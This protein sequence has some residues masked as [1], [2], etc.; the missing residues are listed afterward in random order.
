MAIWNLSKLFLLCVVL[1]LSG[2][3]SGAKDM[4]WETSTQPVYQAGPGTAV[5]GKRWSMGARS[6]DVNFYIHLDAQTNMQRG[7]WYGEIRSYE[8]FYIKAYLVTQDGQ[9]LFLKLKDVKARGPDSAY[10]SWKDGPVTTRYQS[11]TFDFK[12]KELKT[13]STYSA[14]VIGYS[15]YKNSKKVKNISFPLKTFGKKLSELDAM[16]TSQGGDFFLMTEDQIQN[17]PIRNLPSFYRSRWQKSLNE[18]S[19]KL[20]RP[21][22]ELNSLSI[23]SIKKLVRDSA[24]AIK[25]NRHQAIYDQEPNWLDLN[26][27]PK[28]DVSYCRNIGRE[29]YANDILVGGNFSYGKIKG[30]IWRSK[31]SIVRIY[32]GSI[33]LGIEPD[34]YRAKSAAYYY[35]VRKKGALGVRPAKN[36]LIR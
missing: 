26:I 21:M 10:G 7:N 29:A 16:I 1:S 17:T 35:I 30:V 12:R 14:F 6:S 19:Q 28:P 32:G 2:A 5:I 34:I 20:S 33:E 4:S 24:K 22:S 15:S 18:V 31:N 23:T 3:A 27:C 8:K 13:I 11:V 25:R 36:M 9:K